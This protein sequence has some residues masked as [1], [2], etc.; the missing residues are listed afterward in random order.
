MRTVLAILIVFSLVFQAQ[1]VKVQKLPFVSDF[2]IG[3]VNGVGFGLNFGFNAGIDVWGAK[4][5]P[6]IEQ[7]ILDVDYSASVNCTRYGGYINFPG[8]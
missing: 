4:I 5:G 3:I 8:A 1:A 7:L 6:E 2:H